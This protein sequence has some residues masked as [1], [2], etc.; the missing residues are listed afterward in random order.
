MKRQ[1]LM[2]ILA[3]LTTLC[4]CVL[5][6]SR[7][8]TYGGSDRD[9]LY[10]I[11]AGEDGRI[12]M[13]GFT[14]ST[15]GTLTGRTKTGRSGWALCVS[16]DGEVLWSFCT[17]LGTYDQLTTPV[18]HDDGS[19]TMALE[20]EMSGAHEI[21][22]IRL[23]KNGEVI[24]RR[25]MRESKGA[26]IALET[27]HD[28]K[29]YVIG[30]DNAYLLYDLDGAEIERISTEEWNRNGVRHA[31]SQRHIIRIDGEE[32]VLYAVGE[33]GTETALCPVI[34]LYPAEGVNGKLLG[35]RY[36]DL[37][38]LSDGGAAG[39][40]WVMSGKEEQRR[41]QGLIARWDEQG[42]IVF[43]MWMET[44]ILDE[45]V[46]TEDGFACLCYPEETEE[47]RLVSELNW[48]LVFF[49]QQGIIQ[50]KVDLGLCSRSDC[51]MTQL[52]DGAI[53]V[54]QRV[55]EKGMN[56]KGDVKL[57]IVPAE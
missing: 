1:I 26:Y 14:N 31:A 17:R 2:L 39:C 5:A 29:G 38:S 4:S 15:D 52:P 28:L 36:N 40:G 32:G 54:V 56:P 35:S 47:N 7:I 19:V 6:E 20:A 13:T 34:Q 46:Q 33:E 9:A 24:S 53:A 37:I 16:S 44:G 12:V 21:E 22:A 55:W 3:A 25:T 18:V 8:Y 27:A 23:D 49:N 11:A 57:T 10:D 50:R 30:G 42:N 45:I 41:Y 43:E 51:A 48:S